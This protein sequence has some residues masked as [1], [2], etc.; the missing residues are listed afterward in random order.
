MFGGPCS[1]LALH[2]YM[3]K[4]ITCICS[5]HCVSHCKLLSHTCCLTKNA[6]KIAYLTQ[7]CCTCS[8]KFPPLIYIVSSICWCTTANTT[9]SARAAPA[10]GAAAQSIWSDSENT[11]LTRYQALVSITGFTS[12]SWFTGW[13]R[14][15]IEAG[16]THRS[17]KKTPP[18]QDNRCVFVR[19]RTFC[20]WG[21]LT[22]NVCFNTFWKV[23]N[24]IQKFLCFWRRQHFSTH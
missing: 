9:F 7:F 15:T 14:F 2:I 5:L 13:Q 3:S 20:S 6:G 22:I 18:K 23:Y 1:V 10:N 12:A 4:C 21:D 16:G 8:N 11:R 24:V 17:H 19:I